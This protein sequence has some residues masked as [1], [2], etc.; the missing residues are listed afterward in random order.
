METCRLGFGAYLYCVPATLSWQGSQSPGPRCTFH[1]SF[2]SLT[3]CASPGHA[4]PEETL[5]HHLRVARVT[6]TCPPLF[7]ARVNAT[8][9]ITPFQGAQH[10]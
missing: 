8:K 6:S 7:S 2:L 4:H 3:Q 5:S 1:S 10:P 9:D